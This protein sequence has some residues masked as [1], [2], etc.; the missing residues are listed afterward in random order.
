[1]PAKRLRSDT[2]EGDYL[3]GLQFYSNAENGIL[4]R[5]DIKQFASV[6]E[7]ILRKVVHEEVNRGLFHRP[8]PSQRIAA[9]AQ[10]PVLDAKPCSSSRAMILAFEKPLSLPIFTASKIE[11]GDGNP[12]RVVLVNP[13]TGEN[14]P[15][16]FPSPIR[17]EIVV[18]D[19]DFPG[20]KEEWTSEEFDKNIVK[21]RP[22]KRPLITGALHHTLRGGSSVV[23]DIS[24]TDNS[25]WIRSRHFRIG[26]K[27]PGGIHGGIRIQ[28]AIS[29]PFMVKDHRGESYKKH[30]PPAPTDEVWRLEKIGKDGAYH[31]RLHAERINTVYD[32]LEYALH[33]PNRLRSILGPNMSDRTWEVAVAHARTCDLQAQPLPVDRRFP[34]PLKLNGVQELL[35][36]AQTQPSF[37]TLC[38]PTTPL[39]THLIERDSLE[40]RGQET[41]PHQGT[42]GQPIGFGE[43][44][45]PSISFFP[46]AQETLLTVLNQDAEFANDTFNGK[47]ELEVDTTWTR[48]LQP[49]NNSQV[50]FNGF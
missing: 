31:K 21:E 37:Y 19:G 13:S 6:L 20:T 38:S 16:D 32:F 23:G 35:V 41:R 5:I 15:V 42:F 4:E 50:F 2:E 28:E 33:A 17:L 30:H 12:L 8:K 46:A 49:D 48:L 27:V 11:D 10:A 34:P 47:V 22:G 26:V 24:I 45:L 40:I 3:R 18:V 25:S 7:P 14:F 36:N 29:E 43:S 1:M 44:A 9:Q 39:E